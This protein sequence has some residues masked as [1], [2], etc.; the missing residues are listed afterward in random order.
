[1]FSVLQAMNPAVRGG[2]PEAAEKFRQE[3]GKARKHIEFCC[4]IY[5]MQL[6]GGRHSYTSTLGGQY[7]GT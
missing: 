2:D 5:K 6:A 7:L 4:I 1:M 3:L